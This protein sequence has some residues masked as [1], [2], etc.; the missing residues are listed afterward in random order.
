MMNCFEL[1]VTLAFN[2][3]LRRYIK[4]SYIRG[5]FNITLENSTNTSS[6]K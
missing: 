3:N 5:G 1:C 6:A 2:L 4:G